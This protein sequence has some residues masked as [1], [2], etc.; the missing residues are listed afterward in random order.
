MEAREKSIMLLERGGRN[1]EKTRRRA[2]CF[3]DPLVDVK[4]SLLF[5]Q[6]LCGERAEERQR[7]LAQVDLQVVMMQYDASQGHPLIFASIFRP[8]PFFTWDHPG[9][10]PVP[11]V[12]A[13]VRGPHGPRRQGELHTEV[14]VFGQARAHHHHQR[15]F[16]PQHRPSPTNAL[17]VERRTSPWSRRGRWPNGRTPPPVHGAGGERKAASFRVDW[18]VFWGGWH[19]LFLVLVVDTS[20]IE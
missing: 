20:L 2:G 15:A 11:P 13:P 12:P 1:R 4:V 18:G 14:Q 17:R 5:L 10:C 16:V 3:L 19:P 6:S 7:R 8:S 9:M